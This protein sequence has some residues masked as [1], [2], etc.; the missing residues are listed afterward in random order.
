M[1]IVIIGGTNFKEYFGEHDKLFE[2]RRVENTVN[3]R[4]NPNIKMV[5]NGLYLNKA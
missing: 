3:H 4:I 2:I 5:G 1:F